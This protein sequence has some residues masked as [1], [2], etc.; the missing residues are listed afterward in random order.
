VQSWQGFSFGNKEWSRTRNSADVA[1]LSASASVV[2]LRKAPSLPQLKFIFTTYLVVAAAKIAHAA[3]YSGRM[4][5]VSKTFISHATKL[6]IYHISVGIFETLSAL[7][8]K[9]EI[10]RFR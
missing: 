8:L 1:I 10:R 5:D 2:E 7:P 6:R 3:K 9:H 4:Q